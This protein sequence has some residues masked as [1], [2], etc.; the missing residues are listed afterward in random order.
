MRSA[1]QHGDPISA[2]VNQGELRRRCTSC[3]RHNSGPGH[4]PTVVPPH[5]R[6]PIYPWATCDPRSP[7]SPGRRSCESCQSVG[8]WYFCVAMALQFACLNSAIGKFHVMQ[9]CSGCSLLLTIRIAHQLARLN[10][11]ADCLRGF[12]ITLPISFAITFFRT[13]LEIFFFCVLNFGS[14][15]R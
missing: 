14:Q 11:A 8:R 15:E 4:C 9:I 7:R 13:S 2:G 10:N 6:E 5:R 1:V 3:E 12:H